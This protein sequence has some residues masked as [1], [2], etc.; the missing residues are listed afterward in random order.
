MMSSPAA[1]GSSEQSPAASDLVA[2]TIFLLLFVDASAKFFNFVARHWML[3]APAFPARQRHTAG[4]QAR[5][6]LISKIR[7]RPLDEHQYTVFKP[8]QK[9]NVNEQPGQPREISGNVN[10]AKLGNGSSTADSSQAALVVIMES[11]P[12]M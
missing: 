9:K 11:F 8:D 1:Q 2:T 7:P 10:L 5:S 12:R 3:C 6:A 4:N